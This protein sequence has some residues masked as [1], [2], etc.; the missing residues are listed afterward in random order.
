MA[1]VGTLAM[2][3]KQ[4]QVCLQHLQQEHTTVQPKP[5]LPIGVMILFIPLVTL[6]GLVKPLTRSNWTATVVPVLRGTAVTGQRPLSSTRKVTLAQTQLFPVLR[7]LIQ[8]CLALQVMLVQVS[9]VM[10]RLPVYGQAHQQRIVTYPV[11]QAV[12]QLLMTY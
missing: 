1:Q 12:Q 6:L 11:Q 2:C 8:Q 4:V 5:Y 7:V 9:T 10:V 3:L